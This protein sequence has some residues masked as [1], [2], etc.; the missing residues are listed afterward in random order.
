MFVRPKLN[1]I[2]SDFRCVFVYAPYHFRFAGTAL[3]LETAG[4]L[5]LSF[6]MT[7][8][9]CSGF[10]SKQFFFL[11]EAKLLIKGGQKKWLTY[12]L[13]SFQFNCALLLAP[14]GGLYSI[15]QSKAASFPF[16]PQ[17]VVFSGEIYIRFC[18]G[19]F[20]YCFLGNN[21]VRKKLRVKLVFC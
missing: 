16:S 3:T 12:F 20:V 14:L 13:D 19:Y 4:F 1:S 21:S 2:K 15:H 17:L 18:C 9:F 10:V 7:F 6:S 11:F 8:V 5:S